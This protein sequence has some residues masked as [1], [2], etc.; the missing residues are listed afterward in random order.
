MPR[1]LASQQKAHD[2]VERVQDWSQE[3]LFVLF[4]LLG[5]GGR[6]EVGEGW[7]AGGWGGGV[8]GGI[9]STLNITSVSTKH[10]LRGVYTKPRPV[11]SL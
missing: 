4:F 6:V 11:Q 1:S 9:F 5:R 2:E 3:A 7:E 10:T 8:R